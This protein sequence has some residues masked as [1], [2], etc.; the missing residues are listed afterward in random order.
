MAETPICTI[1]EA[2]IHAP[3]FPT[4]LNWLKEQYRAIYGQDVYLE[5]DSQD[6]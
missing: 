2:G 4:V 3:D 5:N 1:D 6:G